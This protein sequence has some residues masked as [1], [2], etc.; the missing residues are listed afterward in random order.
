[1]RKPAEA[2]PMGCA[3]EES[4]R[5]FVAAIE[6]DRA[7]HVPVTA[8]AADFTAAPTALAAPAASRVA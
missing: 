5:R 6:T 8:S 2:F 7:D 1:M 3:G 4:M